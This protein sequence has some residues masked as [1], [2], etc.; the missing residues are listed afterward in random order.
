MPARG[1]GDWLR[2]RRLPPR[3]CGHRK[4]RGAR[5]PRCR[6]RPAGLL[7]HRLSRR[8]G[9][10]GAGMAEF[11]ATVIGRRRSGLTRC[12]A[13]RVIPCWARFGLK[14]ATRRNGNGQQIGAGCSP[15]RF[16]IPAW[17]TLPGPMCRRTELR[18]MSGSGKLAGGTHRH[19]GR[20]RA[21]RCPRQADCSS[22]VDTQAPLLCKSIR[23]PSKCWPGKMFSTCTVARSPTIERAPIRC[24]GPGSAP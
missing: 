7:S 14:P 24:K 8:S 2:H 5:H 9:R 1:S 22:S 16:H 4:C 11:T 3:L 20:A 15:Q 10:P 12:C 21:S 19:S 17:S 18:W 6:V 13:P 23:V